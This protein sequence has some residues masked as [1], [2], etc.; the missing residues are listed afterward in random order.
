MLKL[1]KLEKA[2]NLT[3][4]PMQNINAK[5]EQE[6]RDT[7][8]A[9]R[10]ASESNATFEEPI[11]KRS[12]FVVNSKAGKKH[13]LSGWKYSELRDTINTSCDVLLLEACR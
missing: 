7:E 10:L 12:Q 5:L 2:D 4:K 9:F 13:D 11:L 3:Q 8:M 1:S 6:K